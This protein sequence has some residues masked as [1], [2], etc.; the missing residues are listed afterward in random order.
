VRSRA[1]SRICAWLAI[2]LFALASHAQTPPG[3]AISNTAQGVFTPP[4]GVPTLVLSNTDTITTAALR[5]PST[6]QFLHYAPGY[7]GA[8]ATNVGAAQCSTSGAPAGPFVASPNPTDLAG[9][10]INLGSPVEL[11]GGGAYH[12][13]EAFFVRV[14]DG[15]QNLDPLVAET[16]LISVASQAAGDAEALLAAETG[17]NTGEF[18][19]YLMSGPPPAVPG[20][21]VLSVVA[22][23]TAIATYRDPADAADSTSAG[24]LVDPLGVVF[25]S[26]SGAPVAGA[27]VTLIDSS[28]GLPATVFGDDG[29]SSFP[30]TVPAGGVV[31]DSGGTN[32]A[33]PPG[34]FRFP[35]VAPGTYRLQVEPPAT[36]AFPSAVPDAALQ[37]LPGAPYVLSPGSRGNDFLVPIGPIV[38]VDV[39]LDPAN[40][41]GAFTLVK[42][43]GRATAGAGEFVPYT[44]S[45]GAPNG[46]AGQPAFV[47]DRLPRG[48]RFE[49]GS[50]RIGGAV[51][52]DPAIT[53]DGRTLTIPLG[54][55][56]PGAQLEVRYVARLGAG[57]RSGPAVN[58]ALV[59]AGTLSSNL[60][61]A[62]LL[63]V[64]D[65][66]GERATLVGRVAL[67]NCADSRNLQHTGV[68]GVRV[69]LE[70]GTSVVTDELG[71]FHFP[72]VSSAT[73]VAQLDTQTLPDGLMPAAC[74]GSRFAGRSYSQFVEPQRG[75][76]WRTDFFLERVPTAR[77][78]HQQLTV[79]PN[80]ERQQVELRVSVGGATLRGIA[81]LVMLPDGVSP[82]P[83]TLEVVGESAQLDL[84]TPTPTVRSARLAPGGEVLLRFALAADPAAQLNAL[85]RGKRGTG[86]PVQTPVVKTALDAKRSYT[87]SAT[88]DET[89]PAPPAELEEL[90]D[91]AKFG[92]EWL[93]QV[94]PEDRWVYPDPSAILLIPAVKIGIQHDPAL[95]VRL[96]LNGELVPVLNFDGAQKN[97]AKTTAISRWRG[98][99]LEEGPNTFL[100]ELLNEQ[101]EVVKRIPQKLHSSGP[102]VRA[103]LMPTLS[104]LVADG[105]TTPVVA[106]KMF[107]RWGQPVREGMSGQLA[108][109]PPHRAKESVERARERKLA[110][111]DL[112]A[113][114]FVV[115]KGG[116]ARIELEP[117]TTTGRF[118]LRL[119][120]TDAQR[121]DIEGWL[122]PGRR[123]FAL[124]ALGAS[125]IGFGE[126]SGNGAARRAANVTARG[127]EQR[128]AF[129][130]SG[131][132]G[133]A[134]QVT[135][136]YDSDAKRSVPGERLNRTLDSEEHFALYGDDTEQHSEA[137]S[138]DGY[139][140]KVQR[141]RFYA[142]YGDTE[143]ALGASELARYERVV[144][145]LKSEYYG[146]ALRFSGFATETGQSFAR[147]EL[148]GNG[149][150]GLYRL[151]QSPVLIG[152]DRVRIEVRDRFRPG[153]VLEVRPLVPQIDYDLDPFSGTLHFREPVPSRDALLN[154]VLIVVEYEVDGPGDAISGGGRLAGRW[155]NGALEIGASGIHEGRGDQSGDLIG[156]DAIYQW[157]ET[158]ELRAEWAGSD[159]ETFAGRER[160]LAWL[161][162]A[163]HRSET[164]ELEAYAREQQAGF[165]L[166]Q[167][168]A[169]DQGAR[170]VGADLRWRFR[171]DWSLETSGFHEQ[172]LATSDDRQIAESLIKWDDAG[173]R[174]VHAGARYV[175]DSAPLAGAN[176]GQLLLGG[177]HQF[178]GDK[179]TLRG[180][181]EVGFGSEGPHGDYADRL[182]AG[183]DYELTDWLTLF[184]QHEVTF[185]DTRRGQ[186]TRVGATVTPWESGQVALSLGQGDV[187]AQGAINA[188]ASLA[189]TPSGLGEYGPRTYANLG[190]AQHWNLLEHWG[191][192]LSVDRSQTI[193]GGTT[194][195]FDP[196]VPSF[197][198]PANDDYT[199]V[200]LGVGFSHGATALTSR[201]EMRRGELEDAW[202]FM[203]GALREHE[204]TSYSA[205]VEIFK[206]ERSGA[207]P[208]TEDSY[209]AR[210]SLAH[211]PLDTRWIV[212]E[213]LEV[214]HGL[215]TSGGSG[216]RGDRVVNHVK[217]N[218]TRDERTQVALAYST[219]WVSERIDSARYESLGH[220]VG[221]EAR[222]DI[223]KGWDLALHA[224][225]RQIVFG[226]ATDGHYSIG[227]SLGRRLYRNVWASVGYNVVGFKDD[228][229]SQAD[230]TAKGPFLR[231]RVKVDQDSIREWL[232]FS[233]RLARSARSVLGPRS[234]Q[235]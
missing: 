52:P 46:S 25:D 154:P 131:S 71:R 81:G 14:T 130:A 221:V 105:R 137:P 36:H 96:F 2:A 189:P 29:V 17:P 51:A 1:E 124:V 40:P 158:T 89:P 201:V 80:G 61:R 128:T 57:V 122:A 129:F 153:R 231:L 31:T 168:S 44:L 12:Q 177:H 125:E 68:P 149:T 49:R 213:Q 73:H 163:E 32:Y 232:D 182:A 101:G 215:S 87:Q 84:T 35:L 60:A 18:V 118:A 16:V 82:L 147:D 164:V 90:P 126:H 167:L 202:N 67:G 233:P 209:A 106:V 4:G 110:V 132:L 22:G 179:L 235:R 142:L 97:A 151:S 195:A 144:T 116:V 13:G 228:E 8:L 165:G 15:D 5:T 66:L 38:T 166:G 188:P 183:A 123:E 86:E 220:L 175:R 196:D 55:L 225:A 103:Q 169:I 99:D 39:P 109:A 83:G 205:N 157:N 156:L 197:S 23:D 76:L 70:D 155:L 6:T 98:V 172:N 152:S 58:E 108:V 229:F 200:S 43:A 113:T 112:G 141:E 47:E 140:L 9:A 107:D 186:D 121:E 21:C 37:L 56:A 127:Q 104:T 102:P 135:A 45:A 63:V 28:S 227:A 159:A 111:P 234:A 222:Q 10:P 160:A 117:T 53:A 95:R 217:L 192:D 78:L 19:G 199:A 150:S 191:F 145:G 3:T 171:K 85:A 120:L 193:S 176:T 161:V 64:S 100:A 194:P 226:D 216:L 72:L 27:Q 207:A 139:F 92:A 211:R 210:F 59:R 24:L 114:K 42:R 48:F 133:D 181:S 143:T 174:G 11:L 190:I 26:Q 198:G 88:W 184:A 79:T 65:L 41:G 223:A 203:L 33:F 212:L 74:A 218:F 138:A 178:F 214:E 119:D 91:D 93:A 230:Y 173:R 148:R 204:R 162:S 7:A 115:G 77:G 50:L 146:D 30:S 69:F 208:V 62:T 134:W 206:A 94:G 54:V 180:G 75:S 187:P 20:D 136:A 224:R 185:G 219:K 34:G 170:R